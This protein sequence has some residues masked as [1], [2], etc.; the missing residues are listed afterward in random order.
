M[1]G[2]FYSVQNSGNSVTNQMEKIISVKSDRN[3]WENLWKL[4]TEDKKGRGGGG[5]GG[6]G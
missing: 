2:A 4:S 3:I 6:G 5:G 1:M